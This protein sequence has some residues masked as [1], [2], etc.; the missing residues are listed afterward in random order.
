M[1]RVQKIVTPPAAT[2]VTLA[3]AKDHMR[4]TFA[5]DDA[6]I[7]IYINAAKALSEQILQR[8]LITQTWKM[9]LDYWP[10]WIKVLFGDLQSVTHIKYTDQ[11]EDQ[12]TLSTDVYAVDIN[13]VPGRIILKNNQSWPSDTLSNANPIEIQF[14]TGYGVAEGDVPEDIVSA[15]LLTTAHFYEN[16]ENYLVSNMQSASVE[17][18][19][20]TAK[21][22]LYNHRVWDWVI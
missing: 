1:R 8:K 4:V 15:I 9:Y 17:E 20:S 16:R 22:L 10:P 7:T 5:D 2:P 18:I 3:H 14:V 19:P 11:D 6:L 12:S 21:S 13:S